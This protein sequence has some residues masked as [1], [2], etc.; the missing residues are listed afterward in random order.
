ML[1]MTTPRVV[2]GR[3]KL[4]LGRTIA[5]IILDN[6]GSRSYEH[7]AR[8][9][10]A[11]FANEEAKG[12]TFPRSHITAEGVRKMANGEILRPAEYQLEA[13]AKV[14]KIDFNELL[15]AAGYLQT[16]DPVERVQFALNGVPF[17]EDYQVDRIKELIEKHKKKEQDK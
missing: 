5:Q 2:I 16:S 6:K 17:L 3:D 1:E 8:D 13:I 10:R 14:L 12:R 15:M 7:I 4:N 9:M 11:W